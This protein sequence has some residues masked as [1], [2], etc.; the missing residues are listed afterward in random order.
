MEEFLKK[1]MKVKE[2]DNG[3]IEEFEKFRVE[4]LY[5]MEEVELVVVLGLV[6]VDKL[7]INSKC[8]VEEEVVVME[9]CV[10]LW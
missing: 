2:E 6:E 9:K 4:M 7:N 10:C 5:V 8:K 3:V 1:V